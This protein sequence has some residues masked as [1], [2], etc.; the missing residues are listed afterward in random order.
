MLGYLK[1]RRTRQV[2]GTADR[3]PA[4]DTFL[5]LLPWFYTLLAGP[6]MLVLLVF[7][8]ETTWPGLALVATGI[9]VFYYWRKLAAAKAG[10]LAPSGVLSPFSR[11]VAVNL[12][13]R[14]LRKGRAMN[15]EE[16]VGAS[17]RE[18][19]PAGAGCSKSAWSFCWPWRRSADRPGAPGSTGH[20]G[21]AVAHRGGGRIR[22]RRDF[23]SIPSIRR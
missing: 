21:R 5:R 16:E 13:R 12:W 15:I 20:G 7:R 9:P 10:G 17:S 3:S 22:A 23:G 8:P 14:F 1:L 11:R 4:Y 19:L 6:I 2:D 18:F